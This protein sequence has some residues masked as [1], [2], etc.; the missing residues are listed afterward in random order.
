MNRL[1][2]PALVAL[3]LPSFAPAAEPLR[4]LTYNIWQFG[5]LSRENGPRLDALC[6]YLSAQV[7]LRRGHG[8]VFL[9]EAWGA[10]ARQRLRDCGY[11]YFA[12][13]DSD[14][15]PETGLMVLSRWPVLRQLKRDFAVNGRWS[16]VQDGEILSAKGALFA[17]ID[18]PLGKV[19][20]VDTHLI[21]QYDGEHYDHQRRAQ[22][23]ELSVWVRELQLEEPSAHWILGGDLNV[24]AVP[25]VLDEQAAAPLRADD[26][27]AW[28]PTLFQQLPRAVLLEN[29]TYVPANGWVRDT[30]P[31]DGQLDHL[32]SSAS[33]CISEGARAMICLLYTSDAADE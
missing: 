27:D 30:E 19:W 16:R 20:V 21:A 18:S 14:V 4:A 24:A 32:R 15:L 13:Q 8:L 7:R 33:L 11:P 6:T 28:V 2:L 31:N 17:L 29:G 3:L 9:Q 25:L 23:E 1:V 5:P 26:W 10:S 22:L 12:D